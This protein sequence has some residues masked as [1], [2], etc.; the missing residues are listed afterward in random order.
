M[1]NQID[2]IKFKISEDFIVNCPKQRFGKGIFSKYRRR[3]EFLIIETSGKIVSAPTFLG[4]IT[5]ENLDFF[6]YKLNL[7]LKIKINKVDFLNFAQIYSIEFKK[8][9]DFENNKSV[10]IAA[11]RKKLHEISAKNEMIFYPDKSNGFDNS[12]VVKPLAK[13]SGK[14]LIV[15]SKYEELKAHK[16]TNLV[17]FEQFK[18]E[19]LLKTK[20]ILR[21][22]VKIQKF[23]DLRKALKLNRGGEIYAKDVF[24]SN[25]DVVFNEFK[26]ILS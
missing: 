24:L 19:F 14:S 17:Y 9:I 16:Q 25:V 18:P 1:P 5:N 26:K 12:V 11:L 21:F 22:E 2:K 8:D 23:E 6:L 10:Y 13:T 7:D 4:G 15:Y 20:K 3:D